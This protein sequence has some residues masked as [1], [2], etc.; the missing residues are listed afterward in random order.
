MI[1]A[2]R[3]NTKNTIAMYFVKRASFALTVRALFLERNVSAPPEI[4]PLT[5]ER[6]PCCNKITPMIIIETKIIAIPKIISQADIFKPPKYTNQIF[7][8]IS[9][10]YNNTN[11]TILQDVFYYLLYVFIK[12]DIIN[13]L[14]SK[15]C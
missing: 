7:Y 8:I 9:K 13:N 3:A 14:L 4:A 6:W 15:Y 1:F 12:V 2:T 11:K 5:P 10:K